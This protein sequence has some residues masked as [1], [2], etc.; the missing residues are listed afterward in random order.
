VDGAPPYG[1]LRRNAE[2]VSLGDFA[3]LVASPHDLIEMKR[4]A[5]RP[6][7]IADIAELDAILRLRRRTDRP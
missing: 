2:R 1:T 6:Q 7:D 5:G 4:A 3:V